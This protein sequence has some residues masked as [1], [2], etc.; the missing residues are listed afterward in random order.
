MDCVDERGS[1]RIKADYDP[2]VQRQVAAWPSSFVPT[3][4]ANYELIVLMDDRTV[5]YHKGST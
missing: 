2:T 1:A 4:D 3:A 5:G